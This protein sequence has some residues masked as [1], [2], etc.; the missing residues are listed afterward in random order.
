MEDKCLILIDSQKFQEKIL[1]F[2][3]SEELDKFFNCTVFADK[4]ECRQAMIHGIC[5]ASMLVSKCDS[6][7]V[8]KPNEQK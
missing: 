2:M 1:D 6:F 8:R 7:I 4:P 5:I 3:T